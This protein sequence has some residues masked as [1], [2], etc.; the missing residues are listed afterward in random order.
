M[1]RASIFSNFLLSVF[2]IIGLQLSAQIQPKPQTNYNGNKCGSAD[3]HNEMMQTNTRYAQ[4]ML[5]YENYVQTIQ[6]NSANKTAGIVYKLPVVVHVMHK[7]EAVGS[8]VN[9]SDA[10][11]EAAIQDLNEMYRKIPGSQGDGNGVDVEIEYALAVRDPSGNCTNGIVRV[12]MTGNSAY[13]SNGVNRSATGGI[14]DAALKAISVW[15]QTKYYNIW[16]ISE[17]DNNEGGAG[18]QGYAYFASAHGMS[19]DGAVI[20]SSNFTS[21]TSTT[22]AH[23]L[24]HSLNLYHTFEGDNNGASCPATNGCGSGVGDCCTDIPQHIRSASDCVTG[25]N[26]CTG[27]SRDLFIHNYM[28]Y[29]SDACQNMLTADQK[30]RMVAAVT[31]ARASF[32]SPEN[33]GT[34]MSLV[35]VSTAGVDF[36]ASASILCGTGQSV[37]FM[38]RSTCIPNSYIGLS[39]FSGITHLWTITNG[40]NTYTS[41]A[42]NPTITFTNTGTFNVT[43]QVTNSF[44]TTSTTKTGMI[45]VTSGGPVAACTPGSNNVGNFWQTVYNTTFNTINNS[46]SQYV[47]AAYTNF[48][49]TDNTI[50]TAGNSYNLSISANAEGGNGNEVFE[51]YI[52]YNNNGVFSNPSE[53]IFSG[54]A[55]SGTLGTFTTNVTIP[56]TAVQNT[57]LRM[58]VMGETNTLSASERTCGIN[59]FVGDVEDYG[60]YIIPAGCS[61]PSITG[62]TPGSRCGTG[63]V[64]IGATASAGTVNWYTA[65]TGG[66]AI[67]TGTVF[68]TPSLTTTTTYYVDATNAGCTTASRTA[69][70]ASINAIPIVTLTASSATICAGQS[71]TITA[72]GASTYTWAP[73]GSGTSSTVSPTITTT[74]SV[75]GTSTA[76]CVSSTRTISI[77]VNSI[78]VVTLTPSTATICSGSSTTIT[79]TGASTYTWAPS[80]SG[81]SA[82]VSPT[83]TTIYTVTGTS[84]AGCV[85]APKNA[86][87][88]VNPNP[89]TTATTTGTLTCSNPLVALNSTLAGM[90]YTWTAPTGGSVGSANTQS[91]SVMGIGGVYTLTIV[92]PTTGCTYSTT[93]TVIQNTI[94]PSVSGSTS[95][96][97]TC[98]NTTVTANA[99]TTTSPVSYSWT[100][101]G[102]VSGAATGTITAN[103]AGTYNYTVTNTSNGCTTTGL[104][105][106]TQNTTAPTVTVSGTQTLTCAAPTVTLTGAAS[107]STCTPVWTGG[108]ASGASSYTATASA[109]NIYTL[110]VTNPVNGCTNS[111]ISQVVASSGVPSVT[112]S[113]TSSLS[114]NTLTTQVIATTTTSPVSYNW[115]GPGIVSGTTSASATVNAGGTYTVVVTNTASSC[116]STVTIAVTQN[117]TAP[118]VTG[119]TTGTLTCS[120]LTVNANATTTTTPVSYNWTGPGIVSGAAT[121]TITANMAGTYNYTVANTSNGCKTTGTRSVT[122]NTT[123]SSVTGSVTGSLTCTTLTTSV[124]AT[125]A[126]TPVSYNWSGPGILSGASTGTIVANQAGTYN[127]TVTNTSNGCA[128]TGSQSILQNTVAPTLTVSP[129][130]SSICAGSSVTITASTSAS[131]ILWSN[132]A[133]TTNITVSPTITTVYGVTVTNSTNGCTTIGSSTVNVNTAPNVTLTASPATI[134]SGQSTTLTASGAS[135]YTWLPSGSGTSS[136]FSPTATSVYTVTG[137]SAGG[138]VGAAKMVTVTVNNAPT[139]TVNSP[140]IC[141]GQTATLTASGATSYTWGPG[142]TLSSTTGSSVMAFPPSTAIYTVIGS[143]GSCVSTKSTVVTVN[144]TPTVAISG[145]TNTTCNGLCNGAVTTTVNGTGPFTYSWSPSGGTGGTVTGLCAGNYTVMVTNSAGCSSTATVQINQPATVTSSVATTP[146]SCFGLCDGSATVTASGGTPGYTYSWSPVGTGGGT[147]ANLCAGVYTVNTM[148]QNGCN[149]SVT[150]IISMPAQLIATA[151]STDA[152]CSSC[153]DGTATANFSGGVGLVTYSWSPIGM[154]TQTINNVLPGCYTV[155]VTDANGCQGAASTCVG[156]STGINELL[157]TSI[158][159]YPNPSNGQFII[160]ST[161]VIEKMKVDVT[162]ALGQIVMEENMSN[163]DH[164]SIDLSKMAKGIYYLKLSNNGE[165]KVVKLILE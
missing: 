100:G 101:P 164:I 20:L 2:S 82:I 109:A 129:T 35:P 9:V 90:N 73:S 154:S 105:N 116:S 142:A 118:S 34:C 153:A 159:I 37:S 157:N 131:S 58:R 11:I 147:Q 160:S 86:T 3:I 22:A 45:I 106:V 149:T 53:L 123:A 146:V 75:T 56:G 93:T 144:S 40:T 38:D 120:T 125:T 81:T 158:N 78:P 87:V 140:T 66:T 137:S 96:T 32:L 29:S 63:T 24:G 64:S 114:C 128:T 7:G 26:A 133:T 65:A 130:T 60:V 8:G 136:V 18:V 97:L 156:F 155:V 19:V 126:T 59:L 127:Y 138:C 103:V 1:R 132:G 71:T 88:T 113:V 55:T 143:N 50:V 74:Y 165:S 47:N 99:T 36:D 98:V 151:T 51:V 25:T 139:I 94:A 122:Q 110:T 41:S 162:N 102:I 67:A 49:C 27:T 148:D 44:G 117:T 5:S 15:D 6:N 46:T 72:S 28:D 21:G 163:I 48:S 83:T 115:S 92:N 95:G 33:G 30:T 84:V 91:T 23:E 121:G 89:T 161:K 80:G 16:L 54:T 76:G 68:T 104:R 10:A 119:S 145:F 39:S 70:T 52:D 14:T 79:A 134:C 112:A 135:T 69:V 111:A 13:M 43:L 107:P 42:Q 108:V 12:N 150:F 61:A 77:N 62:T 17:I 85:S 141:A 152:T 57:L 124:R 31:G 4:K